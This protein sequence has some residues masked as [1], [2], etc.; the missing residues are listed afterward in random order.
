[1]DEKQKIQELQRL[2]RERQRVMDKLKSAQD[3]LRL[4]PNGSGAQSDHIM[5]MQEL[6]R[7]NSQIS[8]LLKN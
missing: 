2:E 7:V 6:E 1:M 4:D 8:L 3:R 5:A